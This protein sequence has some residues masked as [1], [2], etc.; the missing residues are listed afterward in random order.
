M[1]DMP[2][3]HPFVHREKVFFVF[4]LFFFQR[5]RTTFHRMDFL[6]FSGRELIWPTSR[7]A[8]IFTLVFV[9]GENVVGWNE[10]WKWNQIYTN[11]SVIF[12]FLSFVF[13]FDFFWGLVE[14]HF[15]GVCICSASVTLSLYPTCE[16]FFSFL[17][18]K[19]RRRKKNIFP[20]CVIQWEVCC[21]SDLSR[22]VTPTGG[23][24]DVRLVFLLDRYSRKAH[25]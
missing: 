10:R 3:V 24:V 8:H 21:A 17:E 13:S 15:N 11:S 2:F 22:R 14:N 1:K 16:G 7:S 6:R 25:F 20:V 12:F 18:K 5:K 9:T 23:V 19:R 4:F